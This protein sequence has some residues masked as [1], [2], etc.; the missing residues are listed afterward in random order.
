MK[1][2]IR[3]V[4]FTIILIVCMLVAYAILIH[5]QGSSSSIPHQVL[6]DGTDYAIST[7]MTP[8]N[9]ARTYSE[10]REKEKVLKR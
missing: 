5:I 2:N 3:K 6:A 10:S 8:D 9:V 1:A 4:H 7:R